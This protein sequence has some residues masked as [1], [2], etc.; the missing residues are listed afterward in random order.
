MH[1]ASRVIRSFGE[2]ALKFEINFGGNE[3]NVT[4]EVLQLVHSGCRILK[5]LVLNRVHTDALNK[6]SKPFSSVEDLTLY[7]DFEETENLTLGLKDMFL[8][9]HSLAIDFGNFI[10]GSSLIHEYP[11][12]ETL[13][14][15][16]VINREKVWNIIKPVIQ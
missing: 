9:I 11:N 15:P 13:R 12:L 1:W 6:I 5:N 7:I 2:F 14:F 4:D 16:F 8:S 3:T 10:D